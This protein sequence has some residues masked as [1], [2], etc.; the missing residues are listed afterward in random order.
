MA[1]LLVWEFAINF[2]A[3]ALIKVDGPNIRLD[4]PK[5][6]CVMPTVAYFSFGMCQ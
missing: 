5:T 3:V 6:D 1:E 2:P 4:Y